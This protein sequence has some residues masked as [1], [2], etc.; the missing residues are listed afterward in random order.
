VR[1]LADGEQ[2]GSVNDRAKSVGLFDVRD[3]AKFADVIVVEVVE[4]VF[5]KH[6]LLDG[7]PNG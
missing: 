3:R 2:L 6:A 5:S 4:L 7:L 1:G